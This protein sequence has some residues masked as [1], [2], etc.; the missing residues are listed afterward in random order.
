MPQM[1]ALETT[2]FSAELILRAST[3][4]AQ[5]RERA[6]EVLEVLGLAGKAATMVS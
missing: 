2:A 3:S 5:R 1:T 4:P 6:L